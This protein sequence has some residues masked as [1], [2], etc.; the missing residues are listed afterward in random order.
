MDVDKGVHRLT[1]A[2]YRIFL[3][4]IALQLLSISEQCGQMF[5]TTLELPLKHR[6]DPETLQMVVAAIQ[7]IIPEDE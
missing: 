3:N 5:N 1:V 6:I 7:N 2:Q 4:T